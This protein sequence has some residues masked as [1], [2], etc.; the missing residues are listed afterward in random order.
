MTTAAPTLAGPASSSGKAWRR[1]EILLLVMAAAMPLAMSTWQVLFTNFAIERGGIDGAAIGIIQSVREIPGFLAFSFVALLFLF[2]EQ[3]IA[4]LSLLVLGLGVILTGLFPS[5]LG[6]LTTTLIMSVGFHYFETAQQSLTLQWTDKAKTPQMLGRILS[7][8]SFASLGAFG[9]VWLLLTFL[10]LG[11]V[12]VYAVGGGLTIAV[13]LLAW[14]AFPRFP[15]G[16]EQKKRLLL[17]KRYWLYYF[18]VFMSGSR[19]QIF[20][21]FSV[22]LLVE[23]F[24]LPVEH[25]TLLFLVNYAVNT[26]AAPWIGRFVARFGERRSL[27]FEY[28][29]LVGVFLGYAFVDALWLAAVLYVLDHL[30][31]SMAL[32]LKTYFQ[33]IADPADISPTAGVAFTI[34]HI[35]AIVIPAAFGLLWLASPALVF[36][37]G[38]GMAAC[39]LVAARFVP[40]APEPGRETTLVRPAIAASPAE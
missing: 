18:L 26:V 2:R 3:T 34:S 39:S 38:A 12:L 33:K 22:L 9:M 19:R 14:L 20:V 17:R 7:T 29:G 24:D 16:I 15:T 37:A 25:V 11:Y 28:A 10:D 13:A 23:K 8:V 6:L 5:Y 4:I 32:A 27:T 30:L 35:A 31:F 1:P 36:V 40:H 21:V